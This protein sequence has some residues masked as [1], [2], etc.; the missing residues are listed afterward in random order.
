MC[1]KKAVLFFAAMSW[2]LVGPLQAADDVIEYKSPPEKALLAVDGEI[3]CRFSFAEIIDDRQNK[4]TLGSTFSQPLASD[5]ID[6]WMKLALADFTAADLLPP[7]D[8]SG[9][10]VD[11]LP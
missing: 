7:E 3:D 4:T 5:G 10:L 2:L 9:E 1:V 6:S 8:E 11:D